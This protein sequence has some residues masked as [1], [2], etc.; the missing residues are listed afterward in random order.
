[1]SRDL[2]PDAGP[3]RDIYRGAEASFIPGFDWDRD[4]EDLVVRGD[5]S[6]TRFAATT[7]RDSVKQA[8]TRFLG[9]SVAWPIAV[10]GLLLST[11]AVVKLG[12]TIPPTLTRAEFM[13][14]L[15]MPVP[16]QTSEGALPVQLQV[17]EYAQYQ[18][19]T[20]GLRQMSAKDLLD[21]ETR[22]RRDLAN[23]PGFMVPY[24]LDALF[25]LEA[26]LAR[27]DLSPTG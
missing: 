19:F 7:A 23:A 22:L 25:V 18:R 3:Q 12:P 27:R 11:I 16:L 15:Q 5:N 26:E 13:A 2:S 20:Q 17:Y 14:G 21:Y 6:S 4:Y 1:M 9:S 8:R 10:C 24:H